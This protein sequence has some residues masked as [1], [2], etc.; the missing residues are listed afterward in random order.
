MHKNGAQISLTQSG[1]TRRSTDCQTTV[2]AKVKLF[3]G[4]RKTRNNINT[5]TLK[6]YE[7]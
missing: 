5:N 4:L 1:V 2:K 3:E 7:K 6:L